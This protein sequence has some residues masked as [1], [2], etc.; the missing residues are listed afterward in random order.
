MHNLLRIML[1]TSLLAVGC[2]DEGDDIVINPD[3]DNDGIPEDNDDGSASLYEWTTTLV[4]QGP[5]PLSGSALVRQTI[6][7]SAFTASITI[8]GDVTG[9]L[10]PWHV[11]LGRCGTGGAIVGT[12]SFYPRLSVDSTGTASADVRIV[13]VLD[14]AGSYSVNVHESDQYFTTII[15]CG[16][17][18]LQ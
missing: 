15:A 17:L 5:Y 12:D 16:E 1:A 7:E 4:G 8:R 10:R 9:A 14:P 18:A 2:D 11:H 6:G 13:T 3:D